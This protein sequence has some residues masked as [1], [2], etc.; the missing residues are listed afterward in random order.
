MTTKLAD[1]SDLP[2]GDMKV[3]RTDN[4]EI[5]L[6]NTGSG[7]FALDNSC[8][9]GGCRLLHGKLEGENLRCLCHGS[10]FNVKTGAVVDGPAPSPQPTIAVIV[11]DGEIFK[12]NP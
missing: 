9:H 11:K 7:V 2:S 8:V 3:V 4:R 10:V 1:L 6:V 5:L 12:A